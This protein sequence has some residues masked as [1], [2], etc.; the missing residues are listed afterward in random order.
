VSLL[1]AI[2]VSFSLLKRVCVFIISVKDRNHVYALESR[3]EATLYFIF[4]SESK[5]MN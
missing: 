3:V 2:S 1:M 5:L 4:E